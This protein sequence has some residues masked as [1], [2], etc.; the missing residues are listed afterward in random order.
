MVNDISILSGIIAIF[1]ISSLIIP[2][3]NSAFD[4]DY[5]SYDSEY[6]NNEVRA[7]D[8]VNTINVF[9]VFSTFI[10]IAL[11]DIGDTLNLPWFLDA[12][13]T[14]LTAIATL[15]IIRNVWIGGGG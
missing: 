5:N 1:L 6:Y 14:L 13:Y 11:W 10:K 4:S 2:Y 15:I 8:S 7:V 3:V 9:S 12:F